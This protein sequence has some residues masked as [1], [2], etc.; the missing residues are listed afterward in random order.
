M[1]MKLRICDD[2]GMD[3]CL[4]LPSEMCPSRLRQMEDSK[5]FVTQVLKWLKEETDEV[6][7]KGKETLQDP[8]Q[9]KLGH[10]FCFFFRL[11]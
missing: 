3:H 11:F 7:V 1:T 8:T 2:L 4:L 10:V 6:V 5:W 9:A